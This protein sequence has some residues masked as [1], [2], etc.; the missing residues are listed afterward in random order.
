MSLYMRGSWSNAE[1]L[2]LSSSRAAGGVRHKG[3]W[4]RRRRSVVLTEMWRIHLVHFELRARPGTLVP[5]LGSIH[6][7]EHVG[8]TELVVA[9]LA[10]EH[11]QNQSNDNDTSDDNTGCCASVHASLGGR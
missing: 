2:S 9:L 1:T 3:R 6:G 7:L 5:H 8:W 4:A 11:G 10:N